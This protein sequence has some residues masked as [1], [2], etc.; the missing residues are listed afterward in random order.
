VIRLAPVGARVEIRRAGFLLVDVLVGTSLL[1]TAALGMTA[2]AAST[3]QLRRLNAERAAALRALDREEAVIESAPFDDL[4]AVHDGSGF[5]V[6]A[7]DSGAVLL[8]ARAGDADGLPGR[9]TVAIPDD[10]G[11]PSRLL[12]VTLR[13][14]WTGGFG[15]QS[16]TRTLR[17]S[18]LGAGS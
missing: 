13:V 17:V 6:L 12:D 3:A 15:P 18:R 14:D 5:A 7:E 16:V 10:V 1:V 2:V 8:R 11:D 9:V 4:L